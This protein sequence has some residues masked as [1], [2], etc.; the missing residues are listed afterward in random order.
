MLNTKEEEEKK[1]NF[2]TTEKVFYLL[3]VIFVGTFIGCVVLSVIILIYG[4]NQSQ[5]RLKTISKN[6]ITALQDCKK[7]N[8]LY[9]DVLPKTKQECTCYFT[10]KQNLLGCTDH[11]KNIIAGIID[12]TAPVTH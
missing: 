5:T 1:C 7:I 10:N 4:Y 9:V 8:G 3:G 12:N 2:T 6:N 11:N